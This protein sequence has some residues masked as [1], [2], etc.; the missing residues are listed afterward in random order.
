MTI[1][2]ESDFSY[3]EEFVHDCIKI[4]SGLIRG[5]YVFD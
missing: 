1:K 2:K 3:E 5:K 4:T